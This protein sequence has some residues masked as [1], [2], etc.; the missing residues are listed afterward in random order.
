[1]HGVFYRL[2]TM[3]VREILDRA[4][5]GLALARKLKRQSLQPPLPELA[6]GAIATGNLVV[7][8]PPISL[9]PRPDLRHCNERSVFPDSMAERDGLEPSGG[10][11]QISKLR[12]SLKIRTP[13]F[14]SKAR[15]W[16]SIWHWPPKPPLCQDQIHSTPAVCA[17]SGSRV[18]RGRSSDTAV[19]AI[20][21][22]PRSGIS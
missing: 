19:A 8:E 16:H 18:I 4:A 2:S 12:I 20:N 11:S 1:M 9:G 13:D 10:G 14:P 7:R 6:I 3:F 21:R 15:I 5:A 22:S 17:I